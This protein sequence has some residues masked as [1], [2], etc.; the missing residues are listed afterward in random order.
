MIANSE[1]PL[2]DLSRHHFMRPWKDLV[3][4]GTWLY[5]ADQDDDEP[6]LVIVPR[7][8]RTGFLP[9]C[10]ALSGAY[11]YDAPQYLAHA[12]KQFCIALGFEDCMANAHKIAEAVHSHLLDLLTIPSNPTSSIV[13][14]DA[15][16]NIE[17]RKQ[18]FEIV[19]QEAL[20]QN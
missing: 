8:R 9:V 10:I 19:E 5:N 12:S 4:F 3:V 17:G 13:L 15:T 1:K 2:I 18:Y 7:Y 20:A 14:G 11:K 16:L 6:A